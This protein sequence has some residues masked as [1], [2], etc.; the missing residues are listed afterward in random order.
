[1]HNR[2]WK[3]GQPL[4]SIRQLAAEYEVGPQV[5]RL[6]LKVLKQEDR[7]TLNPRRQAVARN[8]GFIATATS[9][10]VA[11][12]L[13]HDLYV[14]WHNPEFS[15]IQRGIECAMGQRA[16]PLLT[17]HDPLR[18]RSV[19]PPDLLDLPVSGILLHGHFRDDVL[20][21]YRRFDLPV[22]LVDK[23]GETWDLSSVS[24]DNQQAAFDATMRLIELGH[25]RLAFLRFVVLSVS[26]IDPDSKE[27]ERGFRRACKTAGLRASD[28]EVFNTFSSRR[29]KTS[30][31]RSFLN[32]K[33]RF[34]GVV[35]TDLGR[36]AT[37]AE[38]AKA[39]GWTIPRD[40][41]VVCFQSKETA[42][43]WSGPCTDFEEIGWQAVQALSR[44]PK[45]SPYHFRV[46]TTWHEGRTAGPVKG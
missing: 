18:L 30:P 19:V 16:D 42:D 14:Q 10:L 46:P 13:G 25:R 44:A 15:A 27:R 45:D 35:C 39:K 12:V 7:I 6:A 26:D 2:E 1:L 43:L 22:V 3:Q 24:V 17:V 20:E 32:A 40:L 21:Q 23:P 8:Q 9:N 28:Y 36:A 4:P 31:I 37:V 5:I 34:T 11:L 33:P 38:G 41:S 29:P